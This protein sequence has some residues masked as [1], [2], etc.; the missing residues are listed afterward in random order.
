MSRSGVPLDVLVQEARGATQAAK[1]V[2][3]T[4]DTKGYL[5]Q[6]PGIQLYC[7]TPRQKKSVIYIDFLSTKLFFK[8]F[9]FY[10]SSFSSS[11]NRGAKAPRS[12]R[13][14]RGW[15]APIEVFGR[16]WWSPQK[17]THGGEEKPK[18]L[19]PKGTEIHWII[20]RFAFSRDLQLWF[21]SCMDSGS[22]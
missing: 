8:P 1:M 9:V 11:L 2:T 14:A 21:L 17:K 20:Q 10:H 4:V 6:C 18:K 22:A 19:W 16:K 7:L 15:T 5:C 12:R 13:A 3:W